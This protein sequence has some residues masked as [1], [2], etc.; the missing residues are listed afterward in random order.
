MFD[1]ALEGMG[2]AESYEMVFEPMKPRTGL[3]SVFR[4][5]LER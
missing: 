5:N 1:A 3:V 4:E 2:E